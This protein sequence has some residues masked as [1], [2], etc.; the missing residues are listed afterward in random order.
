MTEFIELL[1][2]TLE[3]V[4]IVIAISTIKDCIRLIFKLTD[5]KGG[6]K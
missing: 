2:S 6:K 4:V 5:K 1:R 3:V